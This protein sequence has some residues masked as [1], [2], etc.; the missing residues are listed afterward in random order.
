[1]RHGSLVTWADTGHPWLVLV[2]LCWAG[3]LMPLLLYASGSLDLW[4]AW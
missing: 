1:M 4:A 3:A 2:Q